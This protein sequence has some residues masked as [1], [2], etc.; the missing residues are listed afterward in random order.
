MEALPTR[1]SSEKDDFEE[2]DSASNTDESIRVPER[3]YRQQDRSDLE[4]LSTHHDVEAARN[5]PTRVVTAQDWTGSDDP[6][7]PFNWPMWKRVS[8]VIIP[9]LFAFVV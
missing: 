7:N 2:H 5:V 4:K 6:E 3:V 1:T 9:A 8:H